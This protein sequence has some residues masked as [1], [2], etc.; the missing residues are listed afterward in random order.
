MIRAFCK[1]QTFLLRALDGTSMTTKPNDFNE[2]P[3]KFTSDA[4]FKMAVA[5]GALEVF[6]TSKQGDKIATNSTKSK[7][8]EKPKDTGKGEND[9]ADDAK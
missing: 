3:E 8:A 7:D 4:T 6:K 9:K 5:A 2:I 1:N